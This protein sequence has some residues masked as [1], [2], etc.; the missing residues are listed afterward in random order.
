MELICRSGFDEAQRIAAAKL[1]DGAFGIKFGRFIGDSATRI[2]ILAEGFDRSR[3][4][5]AECGGEMVGIAGFDDGKASLTGGI[6]FS[7]LRRHSGL[8]SSLGAF[9]MLGFFDRKRKR[10]ELLL[11]GIAVAKPWRGKGIGGRLFDKLI[12][13]AAREGFSRIRLDVTDHNPVAQALYE[14]KGFVIVRRE[15]YPWLAKWLSFSGHATMVLPL[16]HD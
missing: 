6:N 4:I 10:G 8:R 2:A 1:Y 12:A 3:A 15:R 13:H 5:V 7:L 11:D 14:K 9:A 16:S